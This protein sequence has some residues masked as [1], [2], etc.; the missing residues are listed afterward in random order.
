MDASKPSSTTITLFKNG[1]SV[2]TTT[3]STGGIWSIVVASIAAGDVFY[4]KA[5]STGESQ[6]LQSNSITASACTGTLATPVL[7]CASTKGISGTMAAG[8]TITVYLVPTT[9]ASPT[10]NQVSTGG[11]LTYPTSTSFAFVSNG[12]TGSPVLTTGT[13]MIIASNAAGCVSVP[14]FECVTSGSSSVLGLTTNS[15]TLTAPI[16]PYQ[17]SISG[18]GSVA[19][20]IL[21]LFING[22]YV[23][24]NTATG[25]SFSFSNLTLAAGDQIQLY[26]KPS[27]SCMTQSSVFTVSCFTQPPV[28]TTN[29]TGNLLTGATTVTGSSAYPGASVQLYKGISPSGTAVGAAVTVNSSGVWSVATS[30]LVGGDTYYATQ[31]VSG[32]IS[33]SSSAATVLT[34][35]VCPLITGTYTDAS[36]VVSGTVS[37][38][39]TGTIRL[40]Q[41]GALIGSQ[42]VTSATNWIIAVPANTLYYN[43]SLSVTAQA[44]GGAESTGCITSNVACI[45]PATPSITPT[46]ATIN[47]GQTVNFS[48]SNVSANSWYALLDNSGT[49]YA[50]SIFKT[51]ST[52]FSFSSNTF[53][54]AGTYNL[55]LSAD[56]LSGCPASFA[57]ATITVNNVTLPVNF[58]GLSVKKT[59]NGNQ[60]SWEVTNEVDVKEYVVEKSVDGERFYIAGTIVYRFS[61]AASN[62]YTF[63]DN[64][65]SVSETVYY[66]IV[67]EDWKGQHHYS[68]VVLI[69]N[70]QQ[71]LMQLSPNPAFYQTTITITAGGNEKAMV[72]LTDMNGNYVFAKQVSVKAGN[73]TIVLD[74][75]QALAR[76]AYNVTVA[77]QKGSQY[78]TLVLQ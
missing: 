31:T 32:C 75:L 17:T 48:V 34:P 78:S 11:N 6:C 19:G 61:P 35:A 27:T 14:R 62:I 76:G 21:H 7:T 44:T 39:F 64:A 33:P 43:G 60:V 30:A 54:T 58:I 28:I 66:R 41:D 29:S 12:C 50:T 23:S 59:G 18:S 40:Y 2:G 20:D 55:K 71:K 37:P 8:S 26:V 65:A 10:S 69:N 57:T 74:N 56:A 13:Y 5:Q 49:S 9:N 15:Y 22:K 36:T 1:I 42:N 3:V 67:Q 53:N 73:N 45:S 24:T 68:S 77:M 16:Y 52:N 25:T 63:L 47:A 51:T 70:H 46:T 4:A 38:A 72:Y